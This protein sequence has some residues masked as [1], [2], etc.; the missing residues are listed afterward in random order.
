[1]RTYENEC[2][3]C[4]PEIGCFGESCPQRNVERFY[5]DEC[6][7]ETTLREYEGRELCESCL[8]EEFPIIE[9]SKYY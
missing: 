4:P 8:L 9:G 6:G 1:M 7:D 5:C 3:G 2:V